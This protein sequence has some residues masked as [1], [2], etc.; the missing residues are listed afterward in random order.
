MLKLSHA[1]LVFLSGLVWFAVGCFLLPLGLKLL[2]ASTQP[3][4]AYTPLIAMLSQHLGGAQQVALILIAAG[5]LIGYYKAKYVLSKSVRRSI[6]RIQ[7]LPN[8]SSLLSMYSRAYLIL[9]AVMVG[10]GISIKFFG[11]PNDIRG[12]IDVAIG[13][14]MLNGA[15]IFFRNALDM[16]RM[17]VKVNG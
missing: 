1:A 16:R 3:S 11:V 14:A 13:A 17:T 5:L 10:L 8:P 4:D 2:M 15:M 6:A 7:A 9:L 12:A